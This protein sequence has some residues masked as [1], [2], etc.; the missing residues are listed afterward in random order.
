MPG[1]EVKLHN[2]ARFLYLRSGLPRK[3]SRE[4]EV[5]KVRDAVLIANFCP[6]RTDRLA[7]PIR[8]QRSFTD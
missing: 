5:E 2:I 3:K 1:C 7:A 8:Q 4:I 6:E